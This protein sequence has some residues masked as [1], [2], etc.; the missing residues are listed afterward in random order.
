MEFYEDY[1][2]ED[3]QK[4]NFIHIFMPGR[5][6]ESILTFLDPALNS[7]ILKMVT[8]LIFE[9]VFDITFPIEDLRSHG[10][11]V[12]KPQTKMDIIR[13][14]EPK[15]GCKFLQNL[16]NLQSHKNKAAGRIYISYQS[17]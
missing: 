14:L 1:T 5:N 6:L 10:W 2:I 15:T 13:Q 7:G 9:D 16:Q 4:M 3:F 12:L 11:T 17:T 8:P